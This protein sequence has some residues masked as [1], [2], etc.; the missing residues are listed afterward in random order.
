MAISKDICEKITNSIIAELEKGTMPWVKPW[1]AGN[2]PRLPVR[3]GGQPYRGIN[4]LILWGAAQDAGYRSNV[5]MT[6]KQALEYGGAVRKGEKST[7]IVFASKFVKE[8]QTPEGDTSKRAIPFLKGYNVFNAEQIDG[9]PAKFAAPAPVLTVVG[10]G[11]SWADYAAQEAWFNHVPATLRHGGGKAFFSPSQDF[12]QMPPR[13][14]FKS[15]QAYFG[16]LA[17]EFTHWT[18]HTSRLDRT[19]GKRF[20]DNAYAMEELVAELGAAFT[21][22]A[23]GL[24]P[25]IREDHAPYIAGWLK[26]LKGDSKAIVTAAAKA[27][28]ALALLS[29]YQPGAAE[30]LDEAA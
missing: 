5:W 3:H 17:H 1:S 24:Q 14:S 20:G 2:M 4:I 15:E 12:V 10:E 23:L 29:G 26:V 28:D 25:Q 8:E 27:S 16:T 19:F 7:Q 6:F 30:E 18:G 22:A 9:L 21:M 11:K 13:D